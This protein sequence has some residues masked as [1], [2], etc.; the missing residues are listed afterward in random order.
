VK[1]T[2][3]IVV[4][5]DAMGG[6]YAPHAVVQGAVQAAGRRGIAVILTGPA[7][8]LRDELEQAGGAGLPISIEDA[9]QAVAMD[10]APLSAH[11]RKPGSSVRVAAS[12]VA[13]GDADALFRPATRARHFWRRARLSGWRPA[14]RGRPWRSPCRR[15]RAPPSCWMPARTS[16][17][18]PSICASSG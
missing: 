14:S 5:V 10:E 12:I 6:D 11:R 9:P 17:A 1:D 15:E 13:R 18:W 16:T 8:L 2:G 7:N 3:H 4:A